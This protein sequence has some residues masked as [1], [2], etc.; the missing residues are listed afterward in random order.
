M[1]ELVSSPIFVHPRNLFEKKK[2][3][4]RKYVL[5][6]LSRFIFTSYWIGGN[7]NVP[8]FMRAKRKLIYYYYYYY[9][10]SRI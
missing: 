5:E 10:C 4:K 7:V 9:Y 2:N 6:E 8:I 3:K 1:A